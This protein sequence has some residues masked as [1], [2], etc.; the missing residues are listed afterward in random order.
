[1]KIDVNV[2]TPWASREDREA[3]KRREREAEAINMRKIKDLEADLYETIPFKRSQ[4]HVHGDDQAWIDKW[5]K[6]VE[7]ELGYRK[8]YLACM[9]S[10]KREKQFLAK[11]SEGA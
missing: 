7:A 1:M 8:G 11:T 9:M 3:R 5:E 6:E 2:T 10:T 4:A